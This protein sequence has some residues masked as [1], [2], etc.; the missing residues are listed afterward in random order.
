MGAIPTAT[1][2]PIVVGP[3]AAGELY[4]VLLRGDYSALQCG[5]GATLTLC[6]AT[7]AATS[8]TLDVNAPYP[9]FTVG[10]RVMI[11]SRILGLA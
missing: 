8:I 4:R 6:T 10:R 7:A 2:A 9:T 1:L 5:A 11:E 3:V